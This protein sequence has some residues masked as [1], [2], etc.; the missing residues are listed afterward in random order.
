MNWT[1]SHAALRR[2][3]WEWDP[4]GVA[5]CAPQ[6]EYDCMLEPLLDRLEAG[7][8]RSAIGQFLRQ[9]LTFHFELDVAEPL[10]RSV[11][12]RH[13]CGASGRGQATS[14]S[15][16]RA[17]GRRSARSDP[18]SAAAV[19]TDRDGARRMGAMRTVA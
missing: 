11:A 13:A 19:R 5:D 10:A 8:D 12:V 14:I 18:S 2:L 3:L 16:D 17:A 4:S 15:V 9:E 7:A 1:A 6:H